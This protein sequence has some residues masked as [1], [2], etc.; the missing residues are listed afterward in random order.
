MDYI[1]FFFLSFMLSH[2]QSSAAEMNH[3]NCPLQVLPTASTWSLM[4]VHDHSYACVYTRGLGTLT[5]QHNTFWLRRTLTTFSCAPDGVQTL[6]LWISSPTLIE[7]PRHTQRTVLSISRTNQWVGRIVSDQ[8]NRECNRTARSKV[9]WSSCLQD[10][11]S[12]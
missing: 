2:W 11:R 6:G 4:F 5:S 12:T 9:N 10:S 3:V 8:R 7:P 1:F